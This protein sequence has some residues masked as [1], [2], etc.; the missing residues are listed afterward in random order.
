MTNIRKSL[1]L[2][3][4]LSIGLG[5]CQDE[6]FDAP[7][8]ERPDYAG[9]ATISIKDFK[10]KHNELLKKITDNDIIEGVITANDVSGNL[11]KQIFIQDETGGLMVA[12]DRNNIYNDFRIG[13]KIYIETQGLYMGKYGGLPQLGY[14][15]SRNNDDI[16]SIGQM[17]W[18]QVKTHIFKEDYPQPETVIPTVITYNDF[19]EDNY[20]RLIKFEGIRFED[21]GQIFAF[22]TTEGSV[23]TLNRIIRFADDDSKT[24]TGRMSSAA[25]FAGDTI[26]SG[27]GSV[28]G[29]LT[30]FNSTVQFLLR[31][32]ADLNFEPNPDGW[33]LQNSP[34]TVAYALQNMDN[35]QSGWVKGFIV[36]A[37]KPGIND[38]NPIDSND[39]L[40]FE[41][42]FLNNTIVIA[43]S[44]DE[45][46]WQ[47]CLV[48]TL[49]SGS[50]MRTILNLSD[51]ED[52][53]G[54]EVALT[55]SLE[56]ILGA[57]GV[58]VATGA[59]SEFMFGGAGE[60][61]LNAPLTST[62]DPFTEYSVTG[63]QKWVMD[64]YGY[65]KM[66]AFVNPNRY[67]NEDWLISPAMDLTEYDAAH[68]TFDH[69]S[70]YGNNTQDHTLWVSSDYNGGNPGTATWTQVT[71]ANYS[72]GSSWTDWTNSGNLNIPSGFTNQTNIHIALKYLSTTSTAGTWEVKNMKVV[73]GPGDEGGIVNPPDPGTGDGS[74]DSPYDL[75]S[76]IDN[77]GATG[78]YWTKAYIV[79]A[80]DDGSGSGISITDD[81]RFTGPFSV[82]SNLLIAAT[83]SET[84]YANCLPVQLPVGTVRTAL[85][86]VDNPDHLGKE[87]F[88]YG[89]LETYFGVAGIKNVTEYDIEGGIIDPGADAILSAPFTSVLAPF[90]EY[91]VLGDQKW[92]PDSYGYA[93]MTGYVNPTSHEN[94]DW[95]ISPALDLSAIDAAY[96]TFDHVSR[97]GNNTTDN[98]LWISSDYTS[99]DPST[100]TWTQIIIP[101]YSSGSTWT[102]WTNTGNLNIPSAFANKSNIHLALKYLSSTTTAGT[103]EVKNLLVKSGEGDDDGDDGTVDPPLPD[104]PQIFLE[105]FGEGTYTYPNR[106]V[107]AD[108]TDFDNSGITYSDPS[109]NAD[110]R[111]TSSLNAHV[112]MP[113][114]KDSQLILEGIDISGSKDVKLQFDFS[115]NGATTAD[116]IVV[117]I[118]DV[119]Q[120]V[121]GTAIAANVFSTI[122]I[123]EVITATSPL[124][125]EFVATATNN[126]LGFRL[127]NIKLTGNPK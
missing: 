118:N 67:A 116:K 20:G 33:G 56:T 127:D 49:P 18:E 13:Q 16:F 77:Q 22:P 78:S 30:V 124:K 34:W 27:I 120:S 64:S 4:M 123:Q 2:L 101:N 71:I 73:S 72:S 86:L 96:V 8:H 106:P 102:D 31:D 53:I 114:S 28:T 35:S 125:I 21:A 36:G 115:A 99:G 82:S 105:T 41:G 89:T 26:P 43:Q 69:I 93:K 54:K 45:T 38:T 68:V 92:A 47:N 121:P 1:I 44:P 48:I 76:A 23:Q 12:I 29:I 88:L 97:Y 15:Y 25:T 94:E 59:S 39:D 46:N 58:K 111:T 65:A 32:T 3:I 19:N 113:S 95:L 87:V 37:V 6:N 122:V 98:T 79:G 84:S 10:T 24:V 52:N 75:Q 103:W 11:Y 107:I 60:E 110:V 51:H 17:T 50:A 62:L 85:N 40:S 42:P 126:T 100:A 90:A 55:G 7:P 74:K 9:E 14:Q 104:A 57:A 80:V 81:S 61:I 83:S 66:T 108:F 119:E 112:W 70:R 5:G 91:S 117:K 63:D 109:G